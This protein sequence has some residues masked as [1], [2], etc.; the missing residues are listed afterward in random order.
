[1][2]FLEAQTSTLVIPKGQPVHTS[3]SVETMQR[4]GFHALGIRAS[5]P[6]LD[7][8]L[9]VDHY[10]MTQPVFGP[11]PHAG[12]CAVTYMFDDAETGFQNRDSTGDTSV[13]RP[14]DAH[15]AIAGRGIV[16][17]EVPV[18][19]GKVAHG[20]QL[21]VNLSAAT[22]LQPARA[23]HLAREQMPRIAQAHGAVVKL[24]FGRYDDACVRHVG[25]V[26]PTDVTLLDVALPVGTQFHYP[27]QPE[28]TVLVIPINGALYLSGTLISQP[29]ALS[30]GAEIAISGAVA[31]SAQFVILM[32]TPLKELVVRHGPFALSTRERL[33]QAI[34]DYQSGRMGAITP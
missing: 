18:E 33:N 31:H 14:G 6:V 29:L 22:E 5:D 16:H 23:L 27:A 24:A 15:W 1:M 10:H 17:D 2:S 26:L 20:L 13:I 4:P 25:G 7:P 30:A 11:H 3:L 32:G 19:N 12:F 9:M 21:F 28:Q 8:F 34:S